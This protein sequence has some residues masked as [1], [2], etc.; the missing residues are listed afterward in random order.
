[1]KT[2]LVAAINSYPAEKWRSYLFKVLSNGARL[3]IINMLRQKPMTVGEIVK[4]SGLEQSRVSHCLKD[5]K[6]HCFVSSVRQ[7][8]HIRYELNRATLLPII[9]MADEHLKA[10]PSLTKKL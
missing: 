9:I 4:H 3:H 5:L 1:M 10:H 8:K 2:K 7:G 6:N